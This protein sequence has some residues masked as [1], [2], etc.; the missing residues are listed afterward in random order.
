MQALGPSA[1]WNVLTLLGAEHLGHSR[2][3]N[4][5]GDRMVL[6]AGVGAIAGAMLL[7]GGRAAQAV[8]PPTTP[9]PSRAAMLDRGADASV[10]ARALRTTDMRNVL[11]EVKTLQPVAQRSMSGLTFG[12]QSA[13]MARPSKPQAFAVDTTMSDGTKSTISGFYDPETNLLVRYIENSQAF[14]GVETGAV[15]YEFS[16][17]DAEHDV[18]EK[19]RVVASSYNGELTKVI[20]NEPD[21][22]MAAASDP[23]GGCYNCGLSGYQ[24]RGE[25]RSS[26]V[27]WCVI[28]VFGSTWAWWICWPL[29]ASACASAVKACCD[30]IVNRSCRRCQR[31]C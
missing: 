19:F 28:G 16:G 22:A 20:A 31:Y 21:G 2:A 23:C 8:I 3:A 7:G 14:D 25:C 29:I 17:W 5:L 18:P 24:L 26:G 4:L 10:L 11:G 6:R 30:R 15:V 13:S 9:T 27:V 1:T 12:G